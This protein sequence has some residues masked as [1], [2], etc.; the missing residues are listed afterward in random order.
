MDDMLWITEGYMQDDAGN[1]VMTS[2]VDVRELGSR[3]PIRALVKGCRREH[4]L[5]SNEPVVDMPLDSDVVEQRGRYIRVDLDGL[6]NEIVVS[7]YAAPWFGELVRS[8]AA[9]SFENVSVT[10]STL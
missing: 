7:P 2:Y 5:E 8:M 10:Q 3:T 6:V 9:R 4:A 1:L